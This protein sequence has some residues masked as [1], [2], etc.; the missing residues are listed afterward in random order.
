AINGRNLVSSPSTTWSL[1]TKQNN[2]GGKTEIK[3][4]T[5]DHYT[6]HTTPITSK[7]VKAGNRLSS[8]SLEEAEIVPAFDPEVKEYTA[9]VPFSVEKVTVNAVPATPGA[10]VTITGDT[11]EY[12]GRNL[13]SVRVVS[14]EGLKRTYK[15]LVTREAPLEDADGEAGESHRMPTW[16][17]VLL[18]C[19]AAVLLAI[20]VLVII[21]IVAKRKEKKE[22]AAAAPIAQSVESAPSE[23]THP[24]E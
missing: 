3:I 19:A 13:V 10:T 4:P 18:C 24:E 22:E 6:T 1:I 7:T 21:L 15:I 14:P 12:V 20:I 8:L 2:G 9:T 11:L 16:L 17:I 5:Q 23:E